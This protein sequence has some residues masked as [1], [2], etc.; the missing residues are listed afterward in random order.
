MHFTYL[1]SLWMP[2]SNGDS[3]YYFIFRRH[4]ITWV[5]FSLLHIPGAT[6]PRLPFST[7][8][9]VANPTSVLRCGRTRH[10]PSLRPTRQIRRMAQIAAH[11]PGTKC[12]PPPA[13]PP[14]SPR[15]RARTVPALRIRHSVRERVG[16]EHWPRN[17]RDCPHPQGPC[18]DDAANATGVGASRG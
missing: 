3:A 5:P 18:S 16:L 9:G 17:R 8:P 11:S 7:H 6:W 10:T 12:R 2:V 1:L 13:T 14:G 4:I 15:T